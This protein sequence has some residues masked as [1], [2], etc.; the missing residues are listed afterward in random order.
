MSQLDKARNGSKPI[1]KSNGTMDRAFND[2][3]V[4]YNGSLE[5]VGPNIQQEDIGPQ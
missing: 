2:V 1:G 5:N 4:T 3:V